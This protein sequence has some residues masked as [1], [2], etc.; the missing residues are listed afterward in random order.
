M[1]DQI[2]GGGERIAAVVPQF[3]IALW[4]YDREQV[5]ECLM[6]LAGRLEDALVRLDAAELL[7]AQLTDAQ[8]ELAHLRRNREEPT[9][10]VQ[11]AEI[12][13][14]A[15]GLR[16]RAGQHADHPGSAGG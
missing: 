2:T 8:K 6:D 7:H 13:K 1:S 4:G 3:D 9:W 10:S 16:R 11:L 5:E 12:M 14:T 15:E